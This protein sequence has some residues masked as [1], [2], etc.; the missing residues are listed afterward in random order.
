MLER[1]EFVTSSFA[2]E[3]INDNLGYGQSNFYYDSLSRLLAK[4]N[5]WYYGSNYLSKKLEKQMN[6]DQYVKINYD[7]NLSTNE[8]FDNLSRKI[9]I[10]KIYFNNIIYQLKDNFNTDW[11]HQND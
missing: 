1:Y 11:V 4:E 5:K 2:R 3:K 8:N 10:S 7:E 9:G 6:I